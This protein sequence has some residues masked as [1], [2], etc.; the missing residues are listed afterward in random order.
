MTAKYYVNGNGAY[1]GAWNGSLPQE[2]SIEV[3]LPPHDARQIWDIG[4][5]EWKD[6]PPEFK[7]I[8]PVPFWKAAWDL[9]QLK[10]SDVYAALTDP[11]ERYLAELDVEGRKT[12]RR[13]DPMVSRLADLLGYPSDQMDSLWLYV[14][15]HYE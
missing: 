3:P 15:E 2:G 12:Y 14:Q 10:K 7:P 6:L 5:G 11:D 13:D 4:T 9:L 1:L 8:E